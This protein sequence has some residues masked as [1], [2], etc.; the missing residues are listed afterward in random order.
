MSNALDFS[1]SV[2]LVAVTNNTRFIYKFPGT[3]AFATSYYIRHIRTTFLHCADK[4]RTGERP[5]LRC[6]YGW[7]FWYFPCDIVIH[8]L[9]YAVML[10]GQI[11]FISIIFAVCW[12]R[13]LHH[14]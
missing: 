4:I 12:V 14:E 6:V 5:E 8:N 7:K 1:F 10:H 13:V 9:V 3:I 11:I 2:A